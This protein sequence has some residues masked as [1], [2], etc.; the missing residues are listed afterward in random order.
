LD[1]APPPD[2]TTA[3]RVFA[4]GDLGTTHPTSFTL[5]AEAA[6]KVWHEI[7]TVAA[8]DCLFDSDD[9]WRQRDT[10]VGTALARACWT[11]QVYRLLRGWAGEVGWGR[12]KLFLPADRP[13]VTRQFRAR[14]FN[15][16]KAYQ[17][18]T[19]A[20]SFFQTLVYNDRFIFHSAVLWRGC[21]NLRSFIVFGQ[22]NLQAR[23]DGP[24]EMR[25]RLCEASGES[26]S[27]E[28]SCLFSRGEARS[29]ASICKLMSC[30]GVDTRA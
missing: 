26:P 24:T 6:D 21:L 2:P 22:R 10:L 30:S 4:G 9:Q 1:T 18:H 7:G 28:G 17:E 16:A 14:G 8:S 12:V 29:S 25:V 5:I 15:V 20:V 27:R 13:D 23:G 3:R 11:V 19:P